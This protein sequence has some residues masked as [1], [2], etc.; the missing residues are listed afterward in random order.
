MPSIFHRRVFIAAS[1]LAIVAT[2]IA[3]NGCSTTYPRR[4]PS[5]EMFPSVAGET[6][7][8]KA[9]RLP[10][11]FTGRPVLLLIGYEQDTQFD[12]DRWLLGLQQAGVAVDVREVPTIPGMIPRMFSGAIDNGMRSGIPDEDWGSVI[13]VYGDAKKIAEFTGNENALPGRILLLD[14]EGKVRYFHDEGYSVGSLTRLQEALES[15]G[16]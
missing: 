6:L 15:L 5:G 16:Q 8:G 7:D 14:G 1:L 13:T 10:E 12:L 9:A 2:L 3:V 4:N 11:D